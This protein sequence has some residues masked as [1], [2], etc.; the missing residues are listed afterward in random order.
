MSKKSA[1][2]GNPP[3]EHQFRSGQSG[4]P[5]GRPIKR[6]RSAT[7]RQFTRDV[8]VLMDSPVTITIDGKPTKMPAHEALLRRH[9]HKALR[10]GHGPSLRFLYKEMREAL[11]RHEADNDFGFIEMA[12]IAARDQR[13]PTENARNYEKLLNTLRK[14]TRNY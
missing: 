3:V 4:N 13:V 7:L 8:L 6:E 14:G 11:E 1:G 2:Y 12:E 5:K 9:L 10:E